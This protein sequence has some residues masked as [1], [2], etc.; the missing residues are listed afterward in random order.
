[1]GWIPSAYCASLNIN[2]IRVEKPVKCIKEIRGKN[3]VKQSLDYSCGPAG[4]ATLLNYYLMDSITEKEIIE[5]MLR[6]T[7]L[8]KIQERGGFSLLDLKRFL[9]GRGYKVT[10]YKMTI[11]QLRLLNKP[12]L[13]PIKFKNFRHFVVVKAVIGDRVYFADP[14]IGNMTMKVEKFETIWQDGIALLV[15]MGE[16]FDPFRRPITTYPMRVTLQDQK[17]VDYETIM[18]NV[19]SQA[20]RTAVHPNEF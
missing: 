10:G 20:I 4:I 11:E 18:R 1:M 14:A 7:D 15:E 16:V 5:A 3:L 12:V 6:V 8:Q 17:F 19:Q 13:V 9:Q 2:G